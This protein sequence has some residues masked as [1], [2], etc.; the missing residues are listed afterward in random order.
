MKV[1]IL[2]FEELSPAQQEDH[3]Y[4]EDAWF[5]RVTDNNGK[6][7]RLESDR[8][9]PEDALFVRNLSWIAEALDE[10]YALGLAAANEG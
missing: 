2:P 6:V 10:A 5:L 8:M 3:P 9:E 4:G 7:I 1:E